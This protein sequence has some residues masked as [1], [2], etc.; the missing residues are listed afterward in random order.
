M[1]GYTFID[2]ANVYQ[3][4]FCGG[5]SKDLKTLQHHPTCDRAKSVEKPQWYGNNPRCPWE[6]WYKPADYKELNC[7]K[8]E[9]QPFKGGDRAG[10]YGCRGEHTAKRTEH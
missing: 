1:K 8:K 7:K 3:C 10:G 4:N 5:Y 6:A 2:I 9:V